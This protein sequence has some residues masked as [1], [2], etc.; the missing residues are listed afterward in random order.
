MVPQRIWRH[1]STSHL[2]GFSLIELLVVVAIFTLL[3]IVTIASNASF[4]ERITLE[5]LAYDVALSVRQAQ[6]YGIAV[7]RF[8]SSGTDF[9]RGYG[10][11]FDV[12]TGP[13]SATYELFAD[14]LSGNGLYDD[15]ELVAATTLRGGYRIVDLC[16]R[17]NGG[18]ENCDISELNIL[19]KR[20]EP[21]AYI[22][23]EDTSP[24]YELGR[25]TIESPSGDRAD[26]VVELSGQISVQ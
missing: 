11:H 17:P 13:S 26:V 4:G 7:Q 22:R 14:T 1:T 12:S 10:M 18:S 2:R 24:T 5:T 9:D 23:S 16:V 6:V 25:I 20:P 21:D 15:G 8:G 3:S 19:F